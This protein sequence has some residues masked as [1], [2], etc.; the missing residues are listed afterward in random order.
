M[1]SSIVFISIIILSLTALFTISTLRNEIVLRNLQIKFQN[2]SS[3]ESLDITAKLIVRETLNSKQPKVYCRII[4]NMYDSIPSLPDK[5]I[6]LDDIKYLGEITSAKFP[7]DICGWAALYNFF[8]L[9]GQ[10][11]ES[12]KYLEK[13]IHLDPLNSDLLSRR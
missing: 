9:A 8:L 5:N 3:V 12:K 6:L 10:E 1:Y 4:D 11:N 13:L 2:S 7:S